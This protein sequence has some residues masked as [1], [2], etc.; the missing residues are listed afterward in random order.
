MKI[1]IIGGGGTLGSCTAYTL[2]LKGLADEL[3]LLDINRQLAMA[4]LMDITTAI[5]GTQTTRIRVGNDEDLNQSDI[6]IVVAGIPHQP[7]LSHLDML[8][9]N[10]PLM[11]DTIRKIDTY[12]PEAIVITATNPA[13]SINL[14]LSLMS[15]KIARTKLLGYDL[16]DSLRFQQAVAKELAKKSTEVEALA[17]GEHAGVLA[18]IFSSVRVNKRPIALSDEAKERLKLDVPQMLKSY[19]ELGINRTA[20]WTSASGISQMVESI[21]TDSRGV[22]PCSA[23]LEGEYGYKGISMGVPVILGKQGIGR[24]I[25]LDLSQDEKKD[26]D[27]SAGSLE[28]KARLV[29]EFVHE[30][31]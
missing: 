10:L 14:A 2:A 24:I 6:V 30:N 23:V 26:L 16:N 19:V 8:R 1:A 3:V 29:R 20:G 9:A 25:E 21:A 12:C 5:V 18:L 17:L 4:H 15:T 22:F 7:G 11:R 13:D 31:R 27:R 28:T